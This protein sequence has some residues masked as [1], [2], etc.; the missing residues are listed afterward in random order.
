MYKNPGHHGKGCLVTELSDIHAKVLFVLTLLF[1]R[2]G[3]LEKL[4]HSEVCKI[5]W[6][7]GHRNSAISSVDAA[8]IRVLA[9]PGLQWRL[10]W[11]CTRKAA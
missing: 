10:A 11:K 2:E 8:C 7:S 1:R 3:G 4:M 5:S 6:P 9:Q